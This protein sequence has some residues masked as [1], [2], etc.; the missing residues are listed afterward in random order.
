MS[1]KGIED[2]QD[3][4]QFIVDYWF[5]KG[6]RVSRSDYDFMVGYVNR[7]NRQ[8]VATLRREIEKEE[9]SIY[10]IDESD[11]ETITEYSRGYNHAIKKVLALLDQEREDK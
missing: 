7:I 2:P 11:K 5:N 3:M 1:N 8:F 4:A 10:E 9:S 6:V